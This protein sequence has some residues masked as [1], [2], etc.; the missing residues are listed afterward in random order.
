MLEVVFIEISFKRLLPNTRVAAP[1][2][3]SLGN[4]MIKMIKL[5]AYPFFFQSQGVNFRMITKLFQ[6]VIYNLNQ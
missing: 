6:V 1:R 4:K 2:L 5:L 3:K